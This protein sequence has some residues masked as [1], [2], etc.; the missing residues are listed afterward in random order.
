[1][2]TSIES[3]VAAPSKRTPLPFARYAPAGVLAVVVYALSLLT[4][5]ALIPVHGGWPTNRWADVARAFAVGAVYDLAVTGWLLLPL[6]LYLTLASSR[7]L[8]R[9][10]NR[11]LLYGTVAIAIGGALFV[12]MAELFFFDEFDGRFNFVAV[13][14]LVY[15]TEVV[16]NIWES[17]PTGRIVAGIA[18]VAILLVYLTRRRR[19]AAQR[20]DW[21]SPAAIS[22]RSA[23]SV[24]RLRRGWH[25]S[26]MIVR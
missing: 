15:P 1:M 26:R 5:I 25:T 2:A 8:G 24:S 23:P 16:N 19:G 17:Y 7:W 9:R 3:R 12:A 20:V 13:D 10:V 4:R 6:V 11:A 22:R 18:A 14:Y 21:R